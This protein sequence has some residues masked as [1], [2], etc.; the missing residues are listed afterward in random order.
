M[1]CPRP[2]RSG[3]RGRLA[4]RT[5]V[6]G[7]PLR[8]GSLPSTQTGK[9]ASNVWLQPPVYGCSLSC[10]G[11]QPLLHRPRQRHGEAVARG[12]AGVGGAHP[13]VLRVY[14]DHQNTGC[15]ARPMTLAAKVAC[16]CGADAEQM[17]T[18]LR[19][20]GA[21]TRGGSAGRT[22]RLGCESPAVPGSACGAKAWALATSM[23]T[24]IIP[25]IRPRQ[26]GAPPYRCWSGG[27]CW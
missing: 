26:E 5:C 22:P 10:T 7:S 17:G 21:T 19:D 24:T 14:S 27:R 1:R 2:H 4:A 13:V 8:V 9:E 18:E 3:R 16:C 15:D 6:G 25:C 11:S 12:Q 20:R 23:A